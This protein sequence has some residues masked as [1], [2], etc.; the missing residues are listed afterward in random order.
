MAK[1]QD[2]LVKKIRQLM[3]RKYG[4]DDRA[5]L[6]SLFD[7]Y[8]Q[9]KDGRIE[10]TE[11]EALLED[12]GIGNSMTRGLWVKGVL[13]AIDQDQNQLIDWDELSR[14]IV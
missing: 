8:D 11:L 5:A 13:G 12:A 3:V 7:E 10:K 14:A 1:E 4:Q 2:E 6:R 9:N